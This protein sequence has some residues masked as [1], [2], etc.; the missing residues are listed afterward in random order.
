MQKYL[1]KNISVVNEGKI[2]IT[3][4]LIGKGRI[5]KIGSSVSAKEKITEIPGEGQMLLPGIIDDQVHFRE[6]GLTEKGTICTESKAAVTGGITSFMEMPN[7]IPNAL[8]KELLEEKYAIASKNALANYSFYMGVSNNNPDDVLRMNSS[9]KNICG[10]KIFMGSSTGNMLVDKAET[11]NKIFRESELLIATHCEDE[12]IISENYQRMKEQKKNLEA[13]DHPLIRTD[14]A[15]YRSSSFAV[16]LAKK[17]GSRLHI[18]HISTEKELP[19][20]EK[21]IPLKQKKITTEVCVHHLHF[22]ADDYEKLGYLIKCN[23]AI[24]SSANKSAL[25]KALLE[26]RLDV[27][28]TDHAPHLWDEKQPPYEK[29]H[30]GLPLVQHALPLMLRYHKEGKISLEKIVEKMSHAVADC[31]AI[32]DRGYIRE[33]YYADLV[34]VDMNEKLTVTKQNI[35]Y[36]CGWSPFENELFPA[37]VTHTF[38]NGNCVYAGPGFDGKWDES[39]KGERLHF[40]R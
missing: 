3:D 38:V 22:T 34:M 39:V 8:T 26:D 4:V 2:F 9:R 17:Y 32:A 11:L 24:K 20:F 29:A 1:F 30:S 36:K 10:V 33:G 37:S 35:L 19:L 5:E 28:A 15:C 27:I 13:S 23:P 7:T 25:W 21:N 16:S 14:E 31:F 12:N 6:P 40:N 18:L